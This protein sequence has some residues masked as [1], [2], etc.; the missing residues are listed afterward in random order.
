[1]GV[2]EANPQNAGLYDKIIAL[3]KLFLTIA[4]ATTTLPSQMRPS[5]K[6]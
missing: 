2:L 1:L 5:N 6:P 3:P 4:L